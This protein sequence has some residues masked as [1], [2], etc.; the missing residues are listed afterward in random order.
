MRRPHRAGCS[1]YPEVTDRTAVDFFA[2]IGLARLG[3]EQ[4]GWS[5]TF[6]NDVDPKKHTMYQSNFGIDEGY[7][8]DDVHNLKASVI[9]EATLWWASFPCTDL[10]LAGYRRGLNGHQSGALLAIFGLLEK[11]KKSSRPP[12]VALENVPGFLSSRKGK[13]F[14][15][16]IRSLNRLGYSC[17]TFLLDAVNFLP[18]SRPRLF[19]IGAQQDAEPYPVVGDALT[20]RDDRLKSPKLS[21]FVSTHKK[22]DWRILDL[23]APP[24]ATGR[25]CDYVERLPA[26]S[27]RWWAD[28][29]IEYLLDQMSPKHTAVID[30]LKARSTTSYAT[31]YRRMR[32][33]RSMAEVR[34]DGIAGCLRTPRGGS[35]RQIMVA[36]GRQR[37]RV[38]YMTPREYAG[39]MGAPDFAIDVSDNQA[40]FGFGDAVAVPVISWIATHVID[41]VFSGACIEAANGTK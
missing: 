40:Y 17:D 29:R 22:L 16:T 20:A 39:L 14:E 8:V 6:S 24:R 25:L 15:T 36:V 10:S 31:V 18:Q 26:D 33:G 11:M 21:E 19:I 30:F 1:G 37:I 7:L 23:P 9:P 27:D 32:H 13:D 41:P 28:D 5:V 38:R 12:L 3:L 2:G 4:A 34:A 35:S